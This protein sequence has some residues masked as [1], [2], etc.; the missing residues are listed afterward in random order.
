MKFFKPDASVFIPDGLAAEDAFR[1]VTHLGIGAHQDDLEIMA[2]HGVQKCFM[3]QELWFGAVTCTNG[4]DS[5]RAGE[6]ACFSDED[7]AALRRREQEKAA[8]LGNYGA[9]VQL[10]YASAEVK[11]VGTGRL[12][13]DLVKLLRATKPEVLYTHNPADKHDTHLAVVFTAI[14]A[15]R[16]LEPAER[17][18]T[19]YGCEVWRGLD[20]M[21]DK[22]KVPLDVG[23]RENLS[24][25][26]IGVYDSQVEGGKRYD[27]AT[28]G[29]RR[30]NA[31][32]FQSHETDAAEQLWF[33]MDLTPLVR[34]DKLDVGRFV[35]GHI[36]KF[37]AGVEEKIKR[38]WVKTR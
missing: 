32:Y 9:L 38:Y 14:A 37:R 34:D 21:D 10:N 22:D 30:A 31:S 36:D 8:I 17:P 24:M 6:Y 1:R 7:M 5:P 25:G 13:S 15:V 27:L 4:G 12:R 3:S 26:L 29:R 11:D 28:L 18:T 35:L 16:E 23:R 19:V 2:F 20:W 33:A